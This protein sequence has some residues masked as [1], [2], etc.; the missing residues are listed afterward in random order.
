MQEVKKAFYG[1]KIVI[2][3]T[4]I[5][6]VGLG[7]FNSTNSIFVKP[8]CDSLGFGRSQFTLHRTIMTLTS[9]CIMPVYGKAIQ[10]LGVKDSAP[11]RSVM[12]SLRQSVIRCKHSLALLS[13]GFC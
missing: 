10:Q 3:S 1:W 2:A 7:M 9:A 5:L 6:A 8:V 4:I 13:V 12:L 11:G